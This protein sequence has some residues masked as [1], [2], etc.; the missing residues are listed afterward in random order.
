[1][2]STEPT[3]GAPGPA[4][5]VR[6]RPYRPEDRGDVYDICIRTGDRGGDA[7]HLYPDHDLLPSIFAGPYVEYDPE[8]AFVLDNGERAVG[9]VIATA[10]TVRFAQQ[11]RDHWLPS[12][13]DR[14]PRPAPDASPRTPT[15]QMLHLL[16]TPENIV[17]P[18]VVA[19]YPAHLHIDILPEYQGAG[20][21]RALMAAC[22]AALAD[23]GVPTVHLGMHPSNTRARAF[24]DRLGFTEIPVP[25]REDVTFLGRRTGEL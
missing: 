2:N 1:M 15:D 4:R 18:Q 25:D 7:R 3:P 14:Y 24:Y 9:Y 23:H 16:H 6:V 10:D 5:Q 8:L 20:H 11:F 21:G 19:E 12:L 22:L 17:L 13:A